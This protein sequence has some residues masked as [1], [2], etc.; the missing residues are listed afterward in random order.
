MLDGD[1]F[2]LSRVFLGKDGKPANTVAGYSEIRYLYDE[3]RQVS[4]TEY[5]DVN[6]ALIKSE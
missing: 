3:N 6:G 1:G 2:V 5:Y 4:R